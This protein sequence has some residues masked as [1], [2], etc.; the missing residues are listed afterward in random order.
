[1]QVHVSAH[2]RQRAAEFNCADKIRGESD[3]VGTGNRVRR[4]DCSRI[5][6][7]KHRQSPS[8]AEHVNSRIGKFRCLG[9]RCEIEDVPRIHFAIATIFTAI[10]GILVGLI[11]AGAITG[12]GSSHIITDAMGPGIVRVDGDTTAGA[13]LY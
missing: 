4:I 3:R 1:M 2:V 7:I 12:I 8:A 10:V 13:F 11:Y 9:Y 5:S 6:S